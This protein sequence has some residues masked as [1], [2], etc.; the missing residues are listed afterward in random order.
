MPGTRLPILPPEAV[1]QGR[2][3]YVLILPWNLAR[4]IAAQMA[5]IRDWGG[6]F[7]VPIPDVKV[8]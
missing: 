2:P 6:Q 4:E 8:F 7:V 3:D 5:A 1:M